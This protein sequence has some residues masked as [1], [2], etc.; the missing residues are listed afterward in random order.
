[1][2][3]ILLKYSTD[4]TYSELYVKNTRQGKTQRRIMALWSLV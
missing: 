1:M 4:W 3:G 2:E